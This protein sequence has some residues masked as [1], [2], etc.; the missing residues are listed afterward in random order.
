MAAIEKGDMLFAHAALNLTPGLSANARRVAGA[1]LEH[2][3]QKT[4]RCDPGINRLMD[5]LGI[6]RTSVVTAITELCKGD[7]GFFKKTSHGGRANCNFY[8]PRWERFRAVM[9]DFAARMK[10]H[11]GEISHR[12]DTDELCRK[13]GT[14]CDGKPALDVTE[15][16]Q[17]TLRRNPPKEHSEEKR[18]EFPDGNLGDHPSAPS[19]LNGRKGSRNGSKPDP[20]RF[21]IHALPGGK[22]IS[23]SEAARS[24]AER[25]FSRDLHAARNGEAIT[26]ALMDATAIYDQAIE[27]ELAR[28]GAGLRHALAALNGERARKWA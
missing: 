24:A 13:T 25:R 4:G 2:F 26:L 19:G 6:G 5:V 15:N 14:G 11:G 7:T 1:L 16:R 8:E 12:A 20:Q 3:N 21:L 27:A 23:H 10:G 18:S 22:S 28:H 17:Q 9:A